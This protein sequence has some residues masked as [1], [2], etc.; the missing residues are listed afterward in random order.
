MCGLV[1]R[2]VTI[3]MTLIYLQYTRTRTDGVRGEIETIRALKSPSCANCIG[4]YWHDTYV[5]YRFE[6]YCYAI[7]LSV[8]EI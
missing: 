3:L 4:S 5:A 7:A 2:H 1:V 8:S 6:N